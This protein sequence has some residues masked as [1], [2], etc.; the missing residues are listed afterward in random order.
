MNRLAA[1]IELEQILNA[2]VA[3]RFAGLILDEVVV[4]H[5]RAVESRHNLDMELAVILVC[6]SD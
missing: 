4:A 3:D 1:V 5:Q 2:D 6:Q